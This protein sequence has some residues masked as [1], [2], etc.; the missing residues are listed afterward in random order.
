MWLWEH[1]P[2]ANAKT[3][4]APRAPAVARP[5]V[6]HLTPADPTTHR[7][8]AVH[9]AQAQAR[10]TGEDPAKVAETWRMFLAAQGG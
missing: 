6:R 9:Y 4:T 7:E 3:K 2:A 10:Q 1:K 5:G 8:L